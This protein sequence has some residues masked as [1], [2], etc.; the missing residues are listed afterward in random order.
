[1][2]RLF[3]SLVLI[4]IYAGLSAQVSGIDSSDY[5]TDREAKLA[6]ARIVRYSGLS[7][8]FTVIEGDVKTVIAYSRGGQ[9]Y[10]AY[11]P[12]FIKRVR[13]V[14]GTDW[15]AISV[16]AHE[17]GHHLSGHTLKLK[18]INQR[19]E[20]E[21]D[22]FSGFILYRMNANLDEAKAALLNIGNEIDTV[23]H[24]PVEIRIQ[25]ISNGWLDA[26]YLDENRDFPADSVLE[27]EYSELIWK[28]RFKGDLNVYFIDKDNQIIWFDNT[29]KP[30]II[31][32]REGKIAPGYKW[33]YHSKGLHYGVDEKGNI[34]DLNFR[35]NV[36]IVGKAEKI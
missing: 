30:V 15:A 24:P 16:L 1:M 11:N 6:I 19:E 12:Y 7:Q 9:R 32:E 27:T 25:A 20:L 10:I 36:Y 26:K 3:L 29:G 5:E 33:F 13:N 8:N 18:G 4:F 35:E 21:A 23:I 2:N 14:A 34:W 17:I 31:G 28:C 22:K